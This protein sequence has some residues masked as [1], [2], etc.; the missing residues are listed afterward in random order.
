MEIPA[1]MVGWL[2]EREGEPAR[3]WAASLPRL[4]DELCARWNLTIAGRAIGGGTYAVVIPVVRAGGK[5]AALK[6]AWHGAPV[7]EEVAGLR[8]WD[9]HGV[10]RLLDADPDRNVLLLEWL[11]PD[12]P[13]STLPAIAAAPIAGRLIRSL[14]IDAPPHV[15]R[16]ADRVETLAAKMP[17]RWMALGRP[18]PEAPLRRAVE[19][20]RRL[21]PQ[22]ASMLVHWDLHHGNIL[23][24]RREPWL[25]IDPVIVAGSTRCRIL[26]RCAPS[27]IGW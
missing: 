26:P 25:A 23:A 21:G 2:I 8:A 24:G 1:G 12:R 9:G 10:V 4:I 11:D 15:E 17:A 18:F 13:L 14:A 20:G 7:R 22:S 3:A 19:T 16:M 5:R 6:C 27:S